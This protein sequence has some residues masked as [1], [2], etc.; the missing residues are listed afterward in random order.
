VSDTPASLV[1]LKAI[2]A[3]LGI[4]ESTALAYSRL[5]TDPLPLFLRRGQL[6]A[7]VTH[8]DE[9]KLRR[10]GGEGLSRYEGWAAIA[11]ALAV[12][13]DTALQWAK[14]PHDPLP[15]AGIGTRKPWCYLAAMR[16]WLYRHDLPL[17][18][19]RRLRATADPASHPATTEKRARA[20]RVAA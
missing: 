19:A 10:S 4:A 9:W 15:V 5:S 13:R 17:Q 20:R 18:A 2:A 1:G 12:D 3:H 7:T 6:R 11:S 8:L 14:L 16:D